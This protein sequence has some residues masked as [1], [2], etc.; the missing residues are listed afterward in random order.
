MILLFLPFIQL[1]MLLI[2]Q[3]GL[4][5]A[6]LMCLVTEL[7]AMEKNFYLHLLVLVML[8]LKEH[9]EQQEHKEL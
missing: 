7:S 8:V 6:L 1:L 2:K 4:I 5:S 9:K 3:V